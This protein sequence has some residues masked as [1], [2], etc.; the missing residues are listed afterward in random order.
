MNLVMFGYFVYTEA[1]QDISDIK[2][3]ETLTLKISVLKFQ[4]C[5]LKITDDFEALLISF[6]Q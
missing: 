1:F 6:L 3:Q 5:P 2:G 4:K